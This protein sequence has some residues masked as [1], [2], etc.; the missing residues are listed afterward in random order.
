MSKRG[1][2]YRDDWIARHKPTVLVVNDRAA[3]LLL[4]RT[5]L[6]LCLVLFC[7]LSGPANSQPQNGPETPKL[8]EVIEEPAAGS[9]TADITDTATATESR[10][11]VK[12]GP[13]DEYDRGVPRTS[14]A[15]YIRAA[16]RD[17]F[18]RAAAYLDL[19]NLPA[20][21]RPA[22]GPELAKQLAIIFERA[23][24]IDMD[25][26][27]TDPEGHSGDGLPASRDLVGRVPVGERKFDILLQRVP[28][29]DGVR[30]WKFSSK[31]VANIPAM[32]DQ[33]GYGPVGEQLSKYLPSPPFL[34]LELWQWVFLI[35]IAFT[36]AALS[37]PVVRL[38]SWLIRRKGFAL[39]GVIARF[40]NGPV[41][42][43]LVVF[44]TRAF[45]DAIQP[46][47]EAMALFKANTIPT[48][49]T[50]WAIIRLTHLLNDYWSLE[51][52]QRNRE[53]AT[54]LLRHILT[55]FNIFVVIIAVL[56]WLDNIGFSVTT[57]LAGLGIGGIAIALA[58]QK[59][60]EHFIGAVTLYLAAPV[61][62]GDFCRFGDKIGTV[63][64]IGLR[65]TQVRTL[66]Q[67]VISVP[68][69]DFAGMQ[70]ENFA[71]RQRFRFAP[72]I[73]LR[74]DTSADQIRFILLE[75]QKLLYAHAKV[76]DSP[77]RVRFVGFGVD[78][79][80]IDIHSYIETTEYDEYLAIAEDLNLRIM[81]IIS[82]SGTEIAIPTSIEY[83]DQARKPD[84]AAKRK[85]EEQV[86]EW[87]D[88]KML[89]QDMTVQQIAEIRNT[90]P[91]PAERT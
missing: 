29:G 2:R 49:V 83:H 38:S 45:K 26:L 88:K 75:L 6:A 33:Y 53:H 86:A 41:H 59:T 54:V 27:S 87:R 82:T 90:I 57:I 34:G 81:G 56:V 35:L 24:W 23:L 60:I 71:V 43:L 18:E 22:D 91:Y 85:V 77:L 61:K 20:G 62:V 10:K 8:K 70:L 30:I 36:V 14:L 78:A 32:Y 76:N 44:I 28:R 74:V 19:R 5:V 80:N 17:D 3:T 42:V 16:K 13:D 65:S 15:G 40:I 39:G 55:T 51:L 64:E 89:N 37:F 4:T 52:Q 69:G 72:R 7:T 48:I 58:T 11:L 50:V 67:T 46:S 31:S 47:L 9:K 66:E 84:S 79:L 21:L 12:F 73:R 1:G 68:T 63:E 25:T